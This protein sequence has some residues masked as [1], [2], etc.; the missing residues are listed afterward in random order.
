M[1]YKVVIDPDIET[2]D[3]I[4]KKVEFDTLTIET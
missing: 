1:I 3:S 4:K 2:I